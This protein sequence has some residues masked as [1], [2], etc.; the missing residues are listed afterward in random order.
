MYFTSVQDLLF[1]NGHGIYVWSAYA[2][3]FTVLSGLVLRSLYRQK[4]LQ[5][6][7]LRHSI[8]EK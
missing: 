7:I 2:I 4:H 6:E 3:G 1:M 5:H 8:E